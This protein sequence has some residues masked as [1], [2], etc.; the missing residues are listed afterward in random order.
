RLET[1]AL[2]HGDLT[3]A[4]RGL[5]GDRGVVAFDASAHGDHALRHGRRREHE[6][7][8]RESAE[9]DDDDQERDDD[10]AP[11]GHAWRLALRRSAASPCVSRSWTCRTYAAASGG[12]SPG[13]RFAS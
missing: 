8:E 2:A 7:P 9:G 5:R 1:I 4:P 12:W 11:P 10:A 13:R 3:D 6:A